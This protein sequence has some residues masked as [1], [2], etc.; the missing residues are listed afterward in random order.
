M[1]QILE[2]DIRYFRRQIAS[3]YESAKDQYDDDHL[4]VD[5]FGAELEA[6]R[7]EQHAT[8]SSPWEQNLHRALADIIPLELVRPLSR[9]GPG[10]SGPRSDLRT[11]AN[12]LEEE[13]LA[14][15]TTAPGIRDCMQSLVEQRVHE[16]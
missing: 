16:R 8:Y 7:L 12:S 9:R 2:E 11:N 14:V 15:Y 10:S 6:E 4:F 3:Y 5:R 1:R 13:N